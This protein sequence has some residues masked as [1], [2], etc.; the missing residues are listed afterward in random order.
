MEGNVEK[1]LIEV[2]RDPFNILQERG[3]LGPTGSRQRAATRDD[4]LDVLERNDGVAA[5]VRFDHIDLRGSDLR[6]LDLSGASFVGCDLTHANASPLVSEQEVTLGPEDDRATWAVERWEMRDIEAIERK[7]LKVSPTLLQGATLRGAILNDANFNFTQMQEAC[8]RE[9]RADGTFLYKANLE[10][11]DIR[12]GRLVRV[13][14]R[15][16]KLG[17]ADLPGAQFETTLLNN[18]CWGEKR[19]V[20]QERNAKHPNLAPQQRETYWE[21]ALQVYRELVR[22]H[23]TAG[24]GFHAGQFRYLRERAQTRLI[25][26]KVTQLS[27]TRATATIGWLLSRPG[28]GSVRRYLKGGLGRLVFLE[29]LYGYGE[30]PWRVLC[31]IGLVVAIFAFAYFEYTGFEFS[32]DGAIRLLDRAGR[33]L[34]FSAASTTALGYGPWIEHQAIGWRAYIGIVQSFV[35]VF[36]N[37]LFVVAFVRRWMR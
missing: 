16:A 13:D 35:G 2:A 1:M 23:D 5:G 14:L 11:A 3:V 28:W 24:S 26:Q 15:S 32:T 36:L 34:Y 37:A 12:F 22:A 33:A 10:H 29:W 7:G 31:A 27:D 17:D 8:L 9:I 30:H 6:G 21:E 18:A 25:R 4:I 19:I 20:R